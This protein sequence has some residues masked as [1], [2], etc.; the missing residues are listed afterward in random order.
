MVSEFSPLEGL[1]VS[2]VKTGTDKK[3]VEFAALLICIC[4]ACPIKLK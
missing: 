1:S 4:I 2:P 3:V